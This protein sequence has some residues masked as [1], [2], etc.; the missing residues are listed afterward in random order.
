MLLLTELYSKISFRTPNPNA[1]ILDREFEAFKAGY[2]I[3][4]EPFYPEQAWQ[5]QHTF[6]SQPNFTQQNTPEWASDFQNLNINAARAT[7]LQAAQFRREAPLQRHAPTQWHQ[8]FTQQNGAQGVSHHQP[9]FVGGSFGS[10]TATSSL[11]AYSYQY[12][13]QVGRESESQDTISFDDAAFDKAFDAAAFE[14]QN[15]ETSVQREETISRPQPEEPSDLPQVSAAYR[16]GS[17]R[18]PDSSERRQ[19]QRS[20]SRDADDLARTAGQLLENVKHD[21][22]TKFQQSNFLLLMRQ[23][24]D[25]EVKVEGDKIVDVEQPLHPG[26]PDYPNRKDERLATEETE[27]LRPTKGK[28]RASSVPRPGSN[29]FQIPEPVPPTTDYNDSGMMAY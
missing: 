25:R 14:I 4:S 5:N 13:G 18:I 11:N 21:Q 10:A 6:T 17:D 15:Q 7:P 16:V 1:G 20:E 12:G 2:P 27:S 28:G 29:G 24:R 8:E 26:G 23:L 9:R 3:A 19:E 22:S